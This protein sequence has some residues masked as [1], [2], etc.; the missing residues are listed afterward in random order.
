MADEDPLGWISTLKWLANFLFT[1]M[2]M[3]KSRLFLPALA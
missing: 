1:E 3:A 2:P